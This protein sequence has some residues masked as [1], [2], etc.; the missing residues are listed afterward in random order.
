MNFNKPAVPF[1]S[2]FTA[3]IAAHPR[4]AYYPVAA[5]CPVLVPMVV[6]ELLVGL[7]TS[8]GTPLANTVQTSL[9]NRGALLRG[10][11][12]DNAPAHVEIWRL[13]S[14]PGNG[15]DPDVAMAVWGVYA[16][17]AAAGL[18]LAPGRV[19]PNHVLVP[20]PNYHTCPWSPP[21]EHEA[22]P[23]PDELGEPARV[24]VIDS[25]YAPE[26]PLSQL[27]VD[28]E[29]GQWFTV[30]PGES[31]GIWVD[32]PLVVHDDLSSFDQNGDGLMDTLVGH[33]NFVAGV[34][35]QSYRPSKIMLV[36]H[37]GAFVESDDSD[38]PIPTEAAV[39]RSFWKHAKESEVVNVG[40]AFPTLPA[41]PLVDDTADPGGP[42]SWSFD[43]IL[44]ALEVDK[45]V[46]VAPAGNQDCA[47]PQYPA[48]F[49]KNPN[50]PNVVG[51][52]SISPTGERSVFSNYGP[53]V[54]CST[55]GEDV[56][57][58][59]VGGWEGATEDEEPEGMP[60]EGTRPAKT[61][62]SGWASWSG[63]SFAAPKV[64]GAIART[65]ANGMG[66]SPLE[67][68]QELKST[69][70]TVT[71]ELGHLMPRLSPT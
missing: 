24:T 57:S 27:D 8:D 37:N 19:A 15:P 7:D 54:S 4:V 43:V 53:W 32:E 66:L 61:F 28:V 40:F 33:A 22:V 60:N 39:A 46:I 44:R 65:S 30:P 25:G 69:H 18:A 17:V 41:A 55:E 38:T 68:W 21:E 6:D 2:A 3:R 51:V 45:H 64:A 70:T 67:A 26:S 14:T 58:I 29:L 59:F 20:A 36:S 13:T 49:G 56:V 12:F 1:G 31:K 47:V 11:V 63:T 34:V 50:Y 52:G 23:V 16:D 42:P 35:I 5:P 71:P 9:T 48:A 10:T 62:E